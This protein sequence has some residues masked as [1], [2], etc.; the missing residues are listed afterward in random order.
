[1]DAFNNTEEDNLSREEALKAREIKVRLQEIEQSLDKVSSPK[2]GKGRTHSAS[3]TMVAKSRK[4]K[5]FQLSKAARFWLIVI[6]V[7]VG[8]RLL[9]VLS[10]VVLIVSM[11]WLPPLIILGLAWVVYELF[12]KSDD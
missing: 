3:Q 10:A 2:R 7:I 6:A 4:T 8:I 5:P 1:M 12:Y 11:T 9:N